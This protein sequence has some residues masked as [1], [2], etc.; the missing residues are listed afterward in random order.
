[1]VHRPMM[2]IKNNRT[3]FNKNWLFYLLKMKMRKNAGFLVTDVRQQ[4]MKHVVWR[5]TNSF[6]VAKTKLVKI[7]IITTTCLF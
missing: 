5:D 4:G 2:T 6:I 7:T 3:F 1:M